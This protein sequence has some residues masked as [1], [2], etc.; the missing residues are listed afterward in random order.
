MHGIGHKELEKKDGRESSLPSPVAIPCLSYGLTIPI[1]SP[2]YDGLT[3]G[4]DPMYQAS[5]FHQSAS[6]DR[7]QHLG[8]GSLTG[9]GG[10]ED[11][12]GPGAHTCHP[13]EAS[14]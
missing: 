9:G 11:F 14:G 6:P 12:F 4:M 7:Q 1:W 5:C 13:P 2:S 10:P 8:N 3:A